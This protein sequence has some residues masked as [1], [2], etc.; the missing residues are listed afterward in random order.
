MRTA[1][2]PGPTP[3]TSTGEPVLELYD[4][5]HD[6]NQLA[7]L[8]GTGLAIERELT[9]ILDALPTAGR[10]NA[11]D[12][13]MSAEQEKILRERGYWDAGDAPR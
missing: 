10:R 9:A 8:A 13:G 6:P 7:N 12:D 1:G 11:I 3:G 2:C 4:L 5:A